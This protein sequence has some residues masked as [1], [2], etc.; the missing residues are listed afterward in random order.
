MGLIDEALHYADQYSSMWD[1]EIEGGDSWDTLKAR[2]DTMPLPFAKLTTE[3]VPAGEVFYTGAEF[4]LDFSIT[5]RETSDWRVY[6]YFDAWWNDIFDQSTRRFKSYPGVSVGSSGDKI[7]RQAILKFYK[8]AAGEDSS[9]AISQSII[10][11]EEK[12]NIITGVISREV[13]SVAS[14]LSGISRAVGG[15][16]IR[17]PLTVPVI[18]KTDVVTRASNTSPTVIHSF[19]IT[20]MKLT[21]IEPL[22]LS[23]G[24]GPLRFQISISADD[25]SSLRTQAKQAR[26]QAKQARTGTQ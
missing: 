18:T 1:I 24:E 23:Y 20:N 21:G 11:K 4:P 19:S 5:L 2:V 6:D 13:G 12:Q 10:E 22:D 14:I 25:V 26:T 16:T 7:H 17:S 15:G 9:I 8:F 3:R